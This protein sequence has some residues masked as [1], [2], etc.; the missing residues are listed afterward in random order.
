MLESQYQATL[1]AELYRRFPGC[2]VLKNDPDYLQGIP[3]LL[4]LYKDRWAALEVK[5]AVDAKQ[6][7][8]QEYYIR[9]LDQ[10]AFAMF[11]YPENN[12]EVLRKLTRYFNSRR[13]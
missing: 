5:K 2:L 1:I 4:V 8:N 6:Q 7:P 13:R 9:E 12:D 11:V 10:M 3:D